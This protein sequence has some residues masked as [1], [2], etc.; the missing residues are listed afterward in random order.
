MPKTSVSVRASSHFDH[1]TVYNLILRD[2]PRKECSFIFSK[3]TLVTLALGDVLQEAGQPIEF[4]YFPNTAMASILNLMKSGKSVEVGLTGKE[5]FVGLPLIAGFRT[6][7]NRI[8][9]Q[10]AGTAFRIDVKDF[11][12]C[13]DQCPQLVTALLSYSQEVAMQTTQIAACNI[14]HDI[15]NR[16]ARWLLMSQDRIGSDDLPLTQEFLSQMLG[17]RRASVSVQAAILQRAG[18]IK[19]AHGQVTVL[20]RKGLENAACECYDTIQRNL[21]VWKLEGK[22]SE[23]REVHSTFSLV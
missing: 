23:V 22:A 17:I 12:E 21:A 16:L 10:A 13:L 11:R 3:L 2:L 14:M 6:S 5:G 8:N 1:N 4:A 7:P 9:T 19:Y 15:S 20:D 18:L